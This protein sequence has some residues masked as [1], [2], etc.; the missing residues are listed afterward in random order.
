MWVVPECLLVDSICVG[1]QKRPQ[2]SSR[3]GAMEDDSCSWVDTRSR[4]PGRNFL[5]TSSPHSCYSDRE[6]EAQRGLEQLVFR[7]PNGCYS[8]YEVKTQ[9]GLE[10]VASS[11]WSPKRSSTS[12]ASRQG[13]GTLHAFPNHEDFLVPNWGVVLVFSAQDPLVGHIHPGRT[14]I[15]LRRAAWTGS[16]RIF[17][18]KVSWFT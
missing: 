9:R 7:R 6:V 8:E 17:A 10:L 14:F 13:P 4:V 2:P 3:G 16:F 15:A 12:T 1:L 18:T 11:S 5:R